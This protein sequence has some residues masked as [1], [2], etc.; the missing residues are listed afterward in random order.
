MAYSELYSHI[1]DSL[2]R[3]HFATNVLSSQKDACTWSSMSV[4][5]V[6]TENSRR[7]KEQKLSLGRAT[8]SQTKVP[9]VDEDLRFLPGPNRCV[10]NFSYLQPQ[11]TFVSSFCFFINDRLYLA[12]N[13]LLFAGYKVVV[14]ALLWKR[15]GISASM[16]R[17]TRQNLSR[18]FALFVAVAPAMGHILLSREIRLNFESNNLKRGRQ[19]SGTGLLPRSMTKTTSKMQSPRGE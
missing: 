13:I 8:H 10:W 14:L 4:V 12:S 6:K 7:L 15:Y 11:Y 9:T 16:T 19:T 5:L 18:E 17:Y 1:L 3:V 2:V